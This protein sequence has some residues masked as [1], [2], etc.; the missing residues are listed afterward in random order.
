MGKN[1]SHLKIGSETYDLKPYAVCNN[2]AYD[3]EKIV[4]C[5]GFTLHDGAEI[6]VLFEYG[7]LF[8]DSTYLLIKNGDGTNNH[9]AYIAIDGSEY[10]GGLIF[11]P[12][13]THILRYSSTTGTFNIVSYNGLYPT[14]NCTYTDLC[15]FAN[16][17]ML[18][19]GQT[20]QIEYDPTIRSIGSEYGNPDFREPSYGVNVSNTP[21]NLTLTAISCNDFNTKCIATDIM[22]NYKKTNGSWEIW[23]S[24]YPIHLASWAGF[25][26]WEVCDTDGEFYY[27]NDS[28]YTYINNIKYFITST[29]NNAGPLYIKAG[30]IGYNQPIYQWNGV[31]LSI[32]QY[33]TIDESYEIRSDFYGVIYRMID[34][35]EN[36]LPYDFKTFVIQHDNY[37]TGMKPTFAIYKLL[38]GKFGEDASVNGWAR[39]NKMGRYYK[40]Y[41]GYINLN[42]FVY[43][44]YSYSTH[45]ERY[46]VSNNVLGGDCYNNVIL[47]PNNTFGD[48]CYG[49]KLL[50]PSNGGNVFGNYCYNNTVYGYRNNFGNYCY[51]NTLG[52]DYQNGANFNTFGNCCYSN[53][54]NQSCSANTFGNNCYSNTLNASCS[55]NAFN[56]YCFNNTLSGA[57]R[58]LFGTY[59]RYN[60]IS[61]S[62][63]SNS[64]GCSCLGNEIGTY[65]ENNSFG[66]GCE[67]NKIGNNCKHNTF[68]N[69]CRYNAFRISKSSTSALRNYC[70]GNIFDPYV[71]NVILY[72][73]TSAS[74]SYI[75]RNIHVY[76]GYIPTNTTTYRY[77]SVSYNLTTK[78]IV[79]NSSDTTGTLQS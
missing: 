44:A 69:Y 70:Y 4:E 34:E 48:Y 21:F 24:L 78:Y 66:N 37:V 76:A 11:P 73:T 43:Y 74:A 67:Y 56:N 50:M 62:S 5:P 49:N 60:I 55:Y 27:F 30:S 40:N 1:I 57:G 54:L 45:G 26:D 20:Y 10:H 52:I 18:I 15:N 42:K 41:G 63:Y 46:F 8:W 33:S 59:C 16:E 58:N 79:R 68:G 22:S 17:D 12:R 77:A 3:E 51:N 39:N 7:N 72:N 19:P 6:T 53:T 64:F 61:S 14:I 13:T 65:C 23:F 71:Q 28:V 47:S 25:H 29:P 31:A 35:F 9:S 32:T 2:S 75:V 38:D 36:D